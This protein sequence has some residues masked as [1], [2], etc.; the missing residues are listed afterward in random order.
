MEKCRICRLGKPCPA[1]GEST[2]DYE[3]L[4]RKKRQKHS[5]SKKGK[6]RQKAKKL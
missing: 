5:G 1:H 6:K 3:A 4:A 2:V